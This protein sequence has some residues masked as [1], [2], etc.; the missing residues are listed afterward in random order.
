MLNVENITR[1]IEASKSVWSLE[2]CNL[3]ASIRGAVEAG[4]SAQDCYDFAHAYCD[5][6]RILSALEL[7]RDPFGA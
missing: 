3:Q 5:N 1:A 6:L 7:P 4:L 2:N